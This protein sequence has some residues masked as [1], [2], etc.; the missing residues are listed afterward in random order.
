MT[1]D[2]S[3]SHQAQ[4]FIRKNI[5]SIGVDEIE[6]KLILAIKKLLHTEN[7]NTDVKLLTG[8]WEGFF[9]L[10]IRDIRIIFSFEAGEITIVEV[11]KIEH[12][13]NVY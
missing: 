7:N 10:R 9:R 6:T 2:F 3:Y 4:K 11:K 12:R 1:F 5:G 13:G 8:E